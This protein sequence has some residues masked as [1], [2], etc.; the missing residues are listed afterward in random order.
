M[1]RPHDKRLAGS[2]HFSIAYHRPGTRSVMVES[3]ICTPWHCVWCAF[4]NLRYNLEV[5]TVFRDGHASICKLKM[6]Q[7]SARERRVLL[8]S[9]PQYLR[10]YYYSLSQRSE[11][12]HPTDIH[13]QMCF[14]RIIYRFDWIKFSSLSHRVFGRWYPCELHTRGGLITG[15]ISQVMYVCFLKPL[16]ISVDQI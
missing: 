12:G 9:I 7:G 11:I 15:I 8:Y 10:E 6:M 5:Q 1:V 2:G 3:Q 14:C 16:K 4:T 13:V